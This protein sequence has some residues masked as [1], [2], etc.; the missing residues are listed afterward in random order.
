[1]LLVCTQKRR[2]RVNRKEQ[3]GKGGSKEKKN[4]T[5]PKGALCKVEEAYP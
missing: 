1:M 2:Q 3:R 5:V 4:E